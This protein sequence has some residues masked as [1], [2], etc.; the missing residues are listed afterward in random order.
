MRLKSHEVVAIKRVIT[1]FDSDAAI[2]LYGSRV[3]DDK[4]GG[5]ID[6]LVLSKNISFLD[7]LKI[8]VTLYAEL[9]EQKIDLLIA[10]NASKPFVKMVFEEAMPL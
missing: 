4:K 9:G 3:D 7:K 6:I 5:D 1:Q 2:Y 8:K 10:E